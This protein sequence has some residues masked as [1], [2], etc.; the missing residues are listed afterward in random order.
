MLNA[1]GLPSEEAARKMGERLRRALIVRSAVR[2][3]GLNL[4]EDRPTSQLA[5]SIKNELKEVH[6]VS[7]RDNVLGLDVFY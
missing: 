2:R 4:G 1:R 6:G 7:I 3:T 5:D